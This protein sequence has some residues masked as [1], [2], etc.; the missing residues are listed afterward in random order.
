MGIKLN[1]SKADILR[2]KKKEL[3]VSETPD[4]AN[5]KFKFSTSS[6]FP[7]TYLVELDPRYQ[8]DMTLLL[9][10]IKELLRDAK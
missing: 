8:I 9:F 5:G 6:T 10:K 3:G 2:Q 1:D 4:F 7:N